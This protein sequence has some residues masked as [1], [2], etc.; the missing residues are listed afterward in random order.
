MQSVILSIPLFFLQAMTYMHRSTHFTSPKTFF[1]GF[2]LSFS[3]SLAFRKARQAALTATQLLK[4]KADYHSSDPLIKKQN[5]MC[6]R[7]RQVKCL[8][9][10]FRLT[11]VG[12]A[13]FHN[14]SRCLSPGL[15]GKTSQELM[16]HSSDMEKLEIFNCF[17]NKIYLLE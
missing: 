17:L 16:K 3:P 1:Y 11:K 13:H 10:A 15:M 7:A 5:K 6:F 4:M 14:S 8:R 12:L 2:Q 9:R